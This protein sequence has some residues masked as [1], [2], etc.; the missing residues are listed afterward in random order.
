MKY[1]K[2]AAVAAVLMAA[3]FG[4]GCNSPNSAEG[5]KGA[6]GMPTSAGA[7]ARAYKARGSVGVSLLTMANPF[8]KVMGDAMQDE[9]KKGGYAVNISAGEMDAARQKDQVND[10]IVKKVSAI[11][12]SPVDSRSIGTSIQEANKAGIPVFTADIG[13]LDPAAK[14]VSHIATDNYGGGKLAGEA[15]VAAIGGKG[16]VAIITHPEVES[17]ILRAKGF[18]EVIAKHPGIKIVAEL[19]GGGQR[20]ASFKTAQDILEKHPDLNGFFAIN[21]PSALGAVAA[22]EKAGKIGKIK[23]VGFDGMPEAKQ[24][25]KDGKIQADIVQYPEKIGALTIQAIEKYMAGEKVPAQTLIPAGTYLK[26]DADKDP[27]LK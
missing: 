21:D 16:T 6:E 1:K 27:S 12:L 14:V 11:V 19:P 17:V 5:P 8:F 10:F 25:I 24:A 3:A 26:A 20:D 7:G 22:I 13:C 15:M 18:K 2:F 4:Q 9:G 23:V